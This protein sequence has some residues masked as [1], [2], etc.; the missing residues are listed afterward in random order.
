MDKQKVAKDLLKLAK[1]I[2]SVQP[3]EAVWSKKF[4]QLTYFN[5]RNTEVSV[6]CETADKAQKIIDK[7]GVEQSLKKVAK[8]AE[9]VQIDN[10]KVAKELFKVAKD[11]TTEDHREAFMW[12]GPK[13]TDMK[14]MTDVVDDELKASFIIRGIDWTGKPR[15]LQ[16]KMQR[17]IEKAFQGRITGINAWDNRGKIDFSINGIVDGNGDISKTKR[18]LTKLFS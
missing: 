13:M 10:K 6:N 2:V 3:K 17:S 16:R 9:E 7:S 5:S 14:V 18:N 12:T 1:E 4:H 11:L 15:E 8:L